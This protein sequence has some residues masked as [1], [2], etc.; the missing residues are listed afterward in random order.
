M[1]L[2][3]AAYLQLNQQLC[4]NFFNSTDLSGIQV[5]HA[6]L[7]I[8]KTKEV[9]TWLIID[10]ITKEFPTIQISIPKVNS[11]PGKIDN[12][13]FEGRHQLERN[14]WD[15]PE[16]KHGIPTPAAK[17]DA[18]LVPL[19]AFDKQGNRVGYGGGFYDRFLVTCRTDCKKIGLSFF[20]MEEKIDDLDEN[21]VPVNLIIT[22][23]M[24]I[25]FK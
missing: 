7:P 23:K 5:L 6:F 12:Y 1:D 25:I 13:Y 4:D 24:R 3:D 14:T 11:Q 22:P 21:D 18:V 10:R 15:I 19:L 2:S 9:N 8:E 20:E 16:P 17:I